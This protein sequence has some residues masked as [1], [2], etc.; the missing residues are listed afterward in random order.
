MEFAFGREQIFRVSIQFIFSIL[1]VYLV[2]Q[3]LALYI[4][5]PVY[6]TKY[7]KALGV[8]QFPDI[9][10]CHIP[11]FNLSK[12]EEHGYGGSFGFLMGNYGN[13]MQSGW[14]GKRTN[15]STKEVLKA[16]A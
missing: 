6:T 4:S 14:Q 9:Y 12:L 2:Y 5:V 3:E 10:V 8:E 1:T 7:K 11:G 16:S 15:S 13:E